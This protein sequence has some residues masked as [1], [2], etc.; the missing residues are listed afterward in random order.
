MLQRLAACAVGVAVLCGP[1]A[2]QAVTP[3]RAPIP[4]QSALADAWRRHPGSSAVDA[5]IAAARARL[6]A[7][8]RPTYNPEAEFSAD[9]NGPDRT[10]TGGL[11]LTLDLGNKRGARRDAAAARLTQTEV[12]ARLARRD[13]ARQ[14]ITALADVHSAR[15]RLRIG[16]RRLDSVHRFADIAKK[17]YTAQDISGLERDLA[18]LALD[19][20]LAEQSTLI[21]ELADAQ[22]RYSAVGGE[23]GNPR[24][25]VL[26]TAQLPGA[27]TTA[28]DIARLPDLQVAQAEAL[29]AQRDIVVAKKNRV[30]DPT[31]GVRIGTIE[32]DRRTRDRVAGFTVSIPLHV[33]NS[34]RAE[35]EAAEADATAAEADVAR[36]RLQLEADQRR[37]IDSYAAARNAWTLWSSSRG[38]DSD[39]RSA[40]LEK[41]LRGGDI[42]PSDFLLQLRQSLDTQLAGAALEARVWRSWTDYLATTGQLERWTGLEATP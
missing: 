24:I 16:E 15:E 25:A 41:L 21:S 4:L 2:A 39:R 13:F 17:Q 34:Y 12:Q 23:T 29:A 1:L 22:A 20:A 28:T 40:L 7:A 8:G 10:A 27:A 3:P 42:S 26:P 6:T 31:V 38:T 11:K 37:A 9:D 33:R 18:Q 14:W 36:L 32:L 5:R 35:V 30:A 19:E